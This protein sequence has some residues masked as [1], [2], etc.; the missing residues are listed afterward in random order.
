MSGSWA[1]AMGHTQFIPT[2]Y[3]A[4]GFDMDK[5]G[6]RDIWNSV[7]DA[8]ATAA[9]LLH[10]NGWR[11][12][13]TWGYEVVLPAQ[14]ESYQD[15]T[16]LISEWQTL[17]FKRPGGRKFP[18]PGDKAVLKILAGTNGPGFLM[19]RNFYVLKR[20]NNANAYALAVGLLADRLAGSKELN[21]PW[22][23]PPGSLSMDEKME[24]QRL[25]LEKG[26][27]QGVVDGYVGPASRS[28]IKR[29]QEQAGI[30]VDGTPNKELLQNLR[31]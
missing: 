6:K 4:Y 15:E 5:N 21:Q 17:G 13:K 2:S 25:L 24:L 1:G 28:A 10:K 12:G 18:R 14:A 7:P 27:Y 8:L 31:R 29:Y 22:P 19:L 3:L 23:R 20:Y 9:N 16:K 30:V 11:P 26:Y